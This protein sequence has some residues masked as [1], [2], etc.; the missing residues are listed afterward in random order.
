MV[1][2]M[3]TMIVI[4]ILI[5]FEVVVL[6]VVTYPLKKPP[7]ID[8]LDFDT[9]LGQDLSDLPETQPV[10]MRDGNTI[11]VCLHIDAV[12]LITLTSL[13]MIWRI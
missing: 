6:L 11:A 10:T 8:S 1:K 5:T 4:F 2:K 12:T 13:R 7:P 9:A 3:L